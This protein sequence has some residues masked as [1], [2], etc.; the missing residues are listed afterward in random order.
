M[1]L[2]IISNEMILETCQYLDTKDLAKLSLCCKHFSTLVRRCLYSSFTQTNVGGIPLLTRTL[3]I[4]PH[5]ASYVIEM[6]YSFDPYG[7]Y[8]CD[9]TDGE[10]DALETVKQKLGTIAMS[11]WTTECAPVRVL[12]R[13][14]AQNLVLPSCCVSC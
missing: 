8:F 4:K 1:I 9:L 14:A 10:K 12:W 3:A 11:M 5:L 6:K 2:G 13:K 7:E